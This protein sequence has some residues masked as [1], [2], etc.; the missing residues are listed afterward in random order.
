MDL[1][2]ITVT[3]NSSELIGGQIQSVISGFSDISCEQ[4]VVDNNSSDNT[5]SLIKNNFSHLTLIENKSNFGFAAANNQGFNISSGEYILFLN[6]DMRLEE[7]SLD[8]I[9]A[10]MRRNPKVGIASPRLV[11]ET[12]RLNLDAKPRRFPTLLNQLALILKIPHLFPRVLD[13][14]LMKDF[15][16]DKEQELDSVRGSFMLVRRDFLDK[17]GWAFDPRYFFWFEDVD[18]CR[19][20]KRLGYTV[21]YT[22]VVSCLDYVGQSIKKRDSL[23]KQKMFTRSMLSYFQKW[24]PWYIWIW[25]A[26]CRPLGIALAWIA[27][28]VHRLN[29]RRA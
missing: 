19:E 5:V 7:K 8:R 29:K 25:I 15:D 9:I 11:D 10:W 2:V 6:P 1:S 3:W 14:Y 4:I 13:S 28:M 16:P 24:E 17:L 23:W 12:G 18:L 27:G 20:A 22:P 21:M 26:L